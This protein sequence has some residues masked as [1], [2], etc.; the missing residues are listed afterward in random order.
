MPANESN[1]TTGHF[2]R[3]NLA[4]H[5]W[6]V[7]FLLHLIWPLTSYFLSSN[8]LEEHVRTIDVCRFVLY[9]STFLHQV[10]DKSFARSVNIHWFVVDL[11]SGNVAHSDFVDLMHQRTHWKSSYNTLSF[12]IASV[13]TPPAAVDVETRFGGAG[14][15][16]PSWARASPAHKRSNRVRH[17]SE[18][19]WLFRKHAPQ[20]SVGPYL[21]TKALVMCRRRTTTSPCRGFQGVPITIFSAFSLRRTERA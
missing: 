2:H 18:C 9:L 4:T 20:S 5:E 3:N 17:L 21:S 12:T 10:R 19:C 1:R 8:L 7:H 11:M 14:C 15:C 16:R 13:S 6:S